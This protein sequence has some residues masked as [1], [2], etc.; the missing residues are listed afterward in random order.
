MKTFFTVKFALLPIAVF[1]F[2]IAYGMPAGAIGAGFLVSVIVGAWRLRAGDIKMLETAT[3]AIFGGLTVGLLLFPRDRVATHAIPLAFGG[4]GVFAI[5]T[6]VR[7]QALDRRV[8]P[9]GVPGRFAIRSSSWSTRSCRRCGA[10]SSAAGDRHALKAGGVVTTA[11]VVVGTIASTLGPKWLIRTALTRRIAE[12]ETY[13][14]PAPTLGDAKGGDFDVA[15]VGAGIGGLTAAALLADAGLKVVVA[16]QHFQAGGFCQSFP[17][18]L[19]HNGEPLVYR[20]DAGPHDFSGVWK[21]GPVTSILERLGV[22]QRIEW[23]RIDHTYR[24]S[25]LVID[26]PRD[27]HDYVAELG[28]LFPRRAADSSALCRHQ[29]PFTTGC[30]RR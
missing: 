19:H 15:V 9:R 6:V 29:A 13:H 16:E 11:I 23:R 10:G 12:L 5:T 26:V 24:F 18:K 21:G 8:F 4:I 25:N 27:W 17:R 30:T 14:W 1:V 2:L 20:F 7:R 28:R 22:A 3:V